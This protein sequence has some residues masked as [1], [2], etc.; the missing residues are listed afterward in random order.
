MAKYIIMTRDWKGSY[1][2]HPKGWK[3]FCGE[4]E[5]NTY[6]DSFAIIYYKGKIMRKKSGQEIYD[7]YESMWNKDIDG[8]D[9]IGQDILIEKPLNNKIKKLSNIKI[10]QKI[11][12]Q[13][14]TKNEIKKRKKQLLERKK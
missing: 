11:I 12:P 4:D 14:M 2:S 3:L 10:K 13:I 5:I 6:G 9:I 1:D 8:Y 7:L